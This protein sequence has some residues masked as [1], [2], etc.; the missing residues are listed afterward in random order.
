MNGLRESACINSVA[1][2]CV[3]LVLK[4]IS[5]DRAAVLICSVAIFVDFF[6]FVRACVRAS[7][8]YSIIQNKWHRG[9]R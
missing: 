6:E 9:R 4:V 5:F 8:I 1:M 7:R 3:P 2:F